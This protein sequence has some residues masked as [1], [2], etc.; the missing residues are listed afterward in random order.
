ML[1]WPDYAVHWISVL[2][3]KWYQLNGPAVSVIYISY[4]YCVWPSTQQIH[5]TLTTAWLNQLIS[6]L[7]EREK[8]HMMI[9][10]TSPSTDKGPYQ[11]FPT[12]CSWQWKHIYGRNTSHCSLL[13]L[14]TVTWVIFVFFFILKTHS[15]NENKNEKI[16]LASGPLDSNVQEI[17]EHLNF[18]FP[19]VLFFLTFTITKTTWDIKTAI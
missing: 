16:V 1:L 5:V 17:S 4:Q 2:S 14:L 7:P 6:S 11:L 18:L 8:M 13:R 12:I 10:V 9:C 3:L 19:F 15:E